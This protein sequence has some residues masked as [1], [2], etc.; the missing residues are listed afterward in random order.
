[1]AVSLSL[2]LSFSLFLS[3]F[4]SLSLSL[5]PDLFR[6]LVCSFLRNCIYR[7]TRHLSPF[8]AACRGR[9]YF[10]SAGPRNNQRTPSNPE[11]KKGG[12]HC[13]SATKG[14]ER[15]R[16]RNYF[17]TFYHFTCG[18]KTLPIRSNGMFRGML[19]TLRFSSTFIF[20][21]SSHYYHTVFKKIPS[22]SFRQTK[23]KET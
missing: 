21:L 23:V 14:N 19:E 18:Y 10:V 15:E 6:F 17:E 4:L 22:I 11:K 9:A 2:S 16:T 13:I 5:L 3:P 8:R 7:S 1:M 12:G 20:M